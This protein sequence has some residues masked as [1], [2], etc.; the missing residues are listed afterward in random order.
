LHAVA[1]NRRADRISPVAEQAIL[2]ACWR[3]LEWSTWHSY[4]LGIGPI[5]VGS[6]APRQRSSC[7]ETGANSSCSTVG[8]MAPARSDSATGEA[9]RPIRAH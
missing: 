8:A 2:R 9:R 1:D 7:R 3:A 4:N 6:S 5:K